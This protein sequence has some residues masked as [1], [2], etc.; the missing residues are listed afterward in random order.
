MNVI[1]IDVVTIEVIPE[2][3]EKRRKTGAEAEVWRTQKCWEV[4]ARRDLRT[5]AVRLALWRD[6]REEVPNRVYSCFRGH[7]A[8]GG[9]WKIWQ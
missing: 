8:I 1:H 9:D 4:K 5:L 7:S 2:H 6:G 3:R